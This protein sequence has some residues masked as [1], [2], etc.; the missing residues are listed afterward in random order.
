MS[1]TRAGA[2]LAAACA[3][4]GWFY[5]RSERRGRA[6]PTGPAPD[7][8]CEAPIE[9][10]PSPADSSLWASAMLKDLGSLD[11]RAREAQQKRSKYANDAHGHLSPQSQLGRSSSVT[12]R[13]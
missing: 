1:S 12:R 11:G 13:L 8:S 10:G 9:R 5:V 4:L 6:S 2:F 3:I 7:L